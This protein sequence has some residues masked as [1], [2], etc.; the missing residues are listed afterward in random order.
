MGTQ[1]AG[2]V[3]PKEIVRALRTIG[4]QVRH[5]RR[6]DS[7]LIFVS[8]FFVSFQGLYPTIASRRCFVLG[9]G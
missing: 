5:T 9:G 4:V 3:A 8:F 6:A 7:F 2:R 1:Q